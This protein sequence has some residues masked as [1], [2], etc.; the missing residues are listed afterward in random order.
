MFRST[1][2]IIV[3]CLLLTASTAFAAN[4]RD[5]ARGTPVPIPPSREIVALGP[6]PEPPDLPVRVVD[7]D[8][9]KLGPQPEPPDYPADPFAWFLDALFSFPGYFNPYK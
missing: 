8:V 7:Q 1:F 5:V 6:Q 2:H 4:W 9:V 3:G